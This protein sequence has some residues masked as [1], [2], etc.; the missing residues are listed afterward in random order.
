MTL[1]NIGLTTAAAVLAISTLG[2]AQETAPAGPQ[3]TQT[4]SAPDSG[5]MTKDQM[6]AQKKQQ[7]QQEKAAKEQAKA[8]KDSANALKHQD[9]ATDAGEK[10]GTITPPPAL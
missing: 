1:K 8:Q 5:V 2:F 7:K 10:A 4:T 3:T 9:K 6:K